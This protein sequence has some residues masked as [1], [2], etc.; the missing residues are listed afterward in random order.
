MKNKILPY[1]IILKDLLIS[2]C[3]LFYFVLCKEN[4]NNS[5]LKITSSEYEVYSTSNIQLIQK[6]FSNI[7]NKIVD[8]KKFIGK[9]CDSQSVD[10]LVYCIK[11][12][13]NV[14][15]YWIL[16]FDDYNAFK[17]VY[18]EYIAPNIA[19]VEIQAAIFNSDKI[20]IVTQIKN[21][22]YTTSLENVSVDE[23][24]KNFPI[25]TVENELYLTLKNEYNSINEKEN[26]FVTIQYNRLVSI[27]QKKLS[28]I[29]TLTKLFFFIILYFVWKFLKN[30]YVADIM[31]MQNFIEN[32]ITLI[33]IKELI[34]IY[35]LIKSSNYPDSY[36]PN[37]SEN[38][39]LTI[40][41]TLECISRT[42]ICFIIL[43]VSIGIGIYRQYLSR[44]ELKR[45]VLIFVAMYLFFCVDQILDSYFGDPIIGPL[46]FKDIKSIF[47]IGLLLGFCLVSCIKSYN[48]LKKKY[49]EIR[50][51]AQE[52]LESINFKLCM[53]R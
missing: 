7:D 36:S 31:A 15:K 28:L 2:I 37:N 23:L 21:S 13:I 5:S 10:Y 33:I 51:F 25:F 47:F 30:R 34:L 8:N 6:T 20:N 3:L 40:V 35:Y 24:P 53:I 46:D 39:I 32:V 38:Y 22:L 26:M 44:T 14:N 50:Y 4:N 52:Y 12:F 43:L 18:A 41:F 45:V 42:F 1:N 29:F 49:D 16:I 11:T 19:G 17:Q 48:T 9:I 27:G